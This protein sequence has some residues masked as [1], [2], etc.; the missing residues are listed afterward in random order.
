MKEEKINVVNKH[1]LSNKQVLGLSG[2]L[3]AMGI[4][5]GEFQTMKINDKIHALEIET[6]QERA[7]VEE[8]EMKALIYTKAREG[9]DRATRMVSP[10]RQDIEKLK[11]W[12]NFEKG[13]DA[14]R[15]D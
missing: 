3:I 8:S 2:V 1:W 9:N 11:A 5:Y 4:S 12:M 14:A 6:I 7:R 15:R 13:E 10:L